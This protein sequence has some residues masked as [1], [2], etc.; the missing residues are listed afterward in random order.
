MANN[1]LAKHLSRFYEGKDFYICHE[2][3]SNKSNLAKLLNCEVEKKIQNWK[4]PILQQFLSQ[5][6]H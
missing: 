1:A 3:S 6:K 5:R 4:A 2:L